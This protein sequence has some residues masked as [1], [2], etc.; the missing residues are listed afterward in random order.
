[1]FASLSVLCFSLFRVYVI[2]D[3]VRV[4]IYMC[5]ATITPTA[6][7]MMMTAIATEG[8][9]EQCN[10]MCV[11][12]FQLLIKVLVLLYFHH[13]TIINLACYVCR[14]DFRLISIWIV[15]VDRIW[16]RDGRRQTRDNFL[17]FFCFCFLAFNTIARTNF[18]ILF[19]CFIFC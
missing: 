2:I 6:M 4:C 16:A 9:P 10:V 14:F 3:G 8:N 12:V 1:M 17:F 11:T 7:V 5:G 15:S 13:A 18:G 19:G